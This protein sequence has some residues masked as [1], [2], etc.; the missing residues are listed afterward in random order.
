MT[1]KQSTKEVPKDEYVMFTQTEFTPLAE[2]GQAKRGLF[3]R[4]EDVGGQKYIISESGNGN[5]SINRDLYQEFIDCLD[6]EEEELRKNPGNNL[7]VRVEEDKNQNGRITITRSYSS[8]G[9]ETI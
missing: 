5:L 8:R 7:T 4:E 6:R 2:A 9:S 3:T 1:E